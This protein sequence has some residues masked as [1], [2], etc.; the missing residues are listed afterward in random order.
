MST[1]PLRTNFVVNLLSPAARIAVALVTIPIYVHHLGDARYGLLNI[2]WILVGYFGFLDLGLSRASTN[3]LAKLR[4]APQSERARVLLTTLMLSLGFGLLGAVLLYAVGIYLFEHVL[5]VPTDLRVEVMRSFPWMASL[6]PMTLVAG[7]GSGALES[8][9]RFFLANMLQVFQTSLGQIAPVIIAV[10]VSPSLTLVIPTVALTQAIGMIVTGVC[11]YRQEGPF[12]LKAFDWSDARSLL[13]YGGWVTVTSIIYPILIGADQFLIGSLI[14]VAEVTYYA[15][16]MNLSLR[17]QVI[18]MALG[19]TFFPRL[20]SLPRDAANKLAARALQSLGYGY[21]AV[22]APAIIF[23]PTFIRYW[24]GPDFAI[25]SGPV[26][27]I[28]VF[29]SWMNGLSFVAYTLAQSQG[30]PDLTGKIHTAEVLPFL[31]ILWVLTGS[32]GIQGAALAWTLRSALDAFAMFW[33]A[34]ISKRDVLSA[35][36]RPAALLCGSEIAA[37]FVGFNLGMAVLTAAL[38]GLISIGFAYAY[39]DDL[40]QV[41]TVQFSRARSFSEGLIRRMKPAQ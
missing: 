4:A 19:R 1:R 3:A 41:L 35:T 17:T 20:S 24:I 27:Q 34:G 28:L 21:A 40:R 10:F 14:G 2:A 5:S 7:V 38:A 29:G 9:E 22:C 39:S 6:F 23:A 11:V 16:P 13:H 8:R 30:R 31:A 32:F 37:R 26:A 33:A 12:S 15:V 36:A 18:P 25:V